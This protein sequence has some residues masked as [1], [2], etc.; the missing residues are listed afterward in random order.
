MQNQQPKKLVVL[1]ITDLELYRALKMLSRAPKGFGYTDRRGSVAGVIT[2]FLSKHADQ[3][4]GEAERARIG[5][6]YMGPKGKPSSAH[7]VSSHSK[8]KRNQ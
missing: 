6:G 8:K 2:K 5:S 3:L 1:R 4:K 7:S